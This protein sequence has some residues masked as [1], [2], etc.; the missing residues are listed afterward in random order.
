MAAGIDVAG[1]AVALTLELFADYAAQ[2]PTDDEVDFA[3]S[4]LVGAMPFHVATARQRMQLA[5]RDAVFDLPDGF[6]ARLPEA[7]AALTADDVRA[8]CRR[9]MRP[10]EAVT[11]AVTTA[12]SAQEALAK[13]GGGTLTTVDHDEY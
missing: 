6:T 4:Y 2:G 13:A 7:L 3:R 11:V 5:V 12:E 8:A 9:Q 10:D 1:P